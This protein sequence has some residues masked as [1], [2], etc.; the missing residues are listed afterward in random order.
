[1][2]LPRLPRL[3]PR[4]LGRGGR[5]RGEGEE[6]VLSSISPQSSPAGSSCCCC[7][8]PTALPLLATAVLARLP[9]EHLLLLLL[10]M[11]PQRGQLW[12]LVR[13]FGAGGRQSKAWYAVCRD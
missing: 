9:L 12:R 5:C 7:S 6:V 10:R 1:M 3:V 11:L 8:C 2:C 4:L 13:L